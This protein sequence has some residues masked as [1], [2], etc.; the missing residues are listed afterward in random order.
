MSEKQQR[1][2]LYEW[3]VL[4]NVPLQKM[5]DPDVATYCDQKR[6]TT[7]R[8]SARLRRDTDE[9]TAGARPSRPSENQGASHCN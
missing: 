8:G 5:L 4:I 1:Y 3:G 2:E 7:E 9:Q 6:R